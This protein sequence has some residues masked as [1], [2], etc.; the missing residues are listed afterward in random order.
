MGTGG[1]GGA[2]GHR[3]GTRN[4]PTPGWFGYDDV[5]C[6]L[7]PR[8]RGATTCSGVH[9]LF[10]GCLSRLVAVAATTGLA[11]LVTFRRRTLIIRVDDA[12]D[13]RMAHDVAGAHTDDGDAGDALQRIERV[14]QAGAGAVRQ[15]DLGEVAGDDHAGALAHAGEPHLHLHGGGVLGLVEDGVGVGQRAAA[16]EGQRGDLDL[17]V[18]EAADDLL[19]GHHVVERVVEGA[20]VGVDLLLH[21]AGEEA[22]AFAGLH[23]GA[24]EHDAVHLAGLQHRHGLGDGEIG[25]AGA[26]G[27]DAEYHVV[28]GQGL[29]VGGLARAARTDGA[30][31]GADGRQIG[32]RQARI[33]IVGQADR[34]LHFGAADAFA[35]FEAAPEAFQ[36]GLGGV[37]AGGLAVDRDP[38]A[39]TGQAH[40]EGLL[41]ADHV[42]VMVAEQQ[43]QQRVVT[44]LEGHGLAV[45]R[46][47]GDSGDG[48]SLAQ[49]QAL[50][51][52]RVADKE[53]GSAAAICT[54]ISRPIRSDGA[55][56]CTG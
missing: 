55:V 13:Q 33:G 4:Q 39:A 48:G 53:L 56:T 6:V 2:G 52:V 49:A 5:Y 44:E 10:A 29:D 22:E 36:G 25:L 17:A 30:T 28:A 34:G 46:G 35:A 11:P 7:E 1:V 47:G 3:F 26:G 37:D 8:L 43:R 38:V 24:G 9:G 16:H 21:V 14:A 19:G 15:I 31:A 54:F 45:G 40:A 23:R 42:A 51:S 32:Q 27:A 18:G 50:S 20:E 12:G 41:D